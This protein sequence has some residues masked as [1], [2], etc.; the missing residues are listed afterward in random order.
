MSMVSRIPSISA[1][2]KHAQEMYL[3]KHFGLENDRKVGLGNTTSAYVC[4]I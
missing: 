2:Q 3:G 4:L 1:L